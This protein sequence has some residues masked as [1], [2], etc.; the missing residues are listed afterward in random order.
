M[1][2]EQNEKLKSISIRGVD[3][4][5]YNQFSNKIKMMDIS[6]GDAVSKLMQEVVDT[7]DDK[8]PDFSAKSL[9][10]SSLAQLKISHQ[11]KL[12][13]ANEDLEETGRAFKIS[14]CENVEFASDVSKETFLAHVLKITH[15]ETVRFP[16]TLPRLLILSKVAFCENVE[17]Y[18]VKEEN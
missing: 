18:D 9:R 5:I 15:C 8:F 3:A 10:L 14:H 6:M 17:F 4:E 7:Y 11:N 12:M 13:I 16:K 2:E 1:S